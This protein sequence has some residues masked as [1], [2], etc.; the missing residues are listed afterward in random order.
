MMRLVC[1][2]RRTLAEDIAPHQP[3]AWKM[4]QRPA[5]AFS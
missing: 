2:M 3:G 4:L 5:A 1:A